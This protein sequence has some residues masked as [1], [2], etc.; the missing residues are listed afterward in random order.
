MYDDSVVT[1]SESLPTQRNGRQGVSLDV[2]VEPVEPV[3]SRLRSRTSRTVKPAPSP[4]VSLSG[5]VPQL[6]GPIQASKTGGIPPQR[7]PKRR[8]TSVGS[9]G[10]T[11]K[12]RASTRNTNEEASESDFNPRVCEPSR[13]GASSCRRAAGRTTSK[14]FRVHTVTLEYGLGKKT[15]YTPP[16]LPS[17]RI[18]VASHGTV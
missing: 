14:N 3:S 2:V 8:S 7:R 17:Q 11:K 15:S 1:Q 12:A 10:A 13:I 6:S 9:G 16:S 18:T 4:S 5:D